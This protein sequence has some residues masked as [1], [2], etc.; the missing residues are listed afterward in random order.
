MKGCGSKILETLP[1]QCV[2]GGWNEAVLCQDLF[3][4]VETV[5][6]ALEVIYGY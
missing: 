6:I 3:S 5:K 1:G 2:K 4:G